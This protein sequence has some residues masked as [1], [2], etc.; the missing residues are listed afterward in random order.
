MSENRGC[1]LSNLAD[2]IEQ[3]ISAGG[4]VRLDRMD[5]HR[6]AMAQALHLALALLGEEWEG[7]R[8]SRGIEEADFG[9]TAEMEGWYG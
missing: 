6:R 1:E 7:F 2:V 3:A 4:D 5:D 9:W 8:L